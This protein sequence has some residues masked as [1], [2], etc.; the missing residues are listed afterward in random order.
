M[1]FLSYYRVETLRIFCSKT[2]WLVIALSL[3]AP[4]LGLTVFSS[5]FAE[6]RAVTLIAQP[7][8]TAA[9]I[10]AVLWALLTLFELDRVHKAGSAVLTDAI[11][12]PLALSAAKL[13][14]LL[15]A[16]L[17][18]GVLAM[19]AYLPYT[20]IQMGNIFDL[21]DYLTIYT[22]FLTAT[23]LIGILFAAIFYQV[24]RR[25][26]LSFILFVVC[27]FV[28]LSEYFSGDYILRWL[29]PMLPT[30][31]DDFSNAWPIRLAVYNRL[32]WLLLLSGLYLFSALCIRRY[33]KG[34][35]GSFVR[36]MRK[37]AIPVL[38]VILVFGGMAAYA[39]QPYENDAPMDVWNHDCEYNEKAFL[40]STHVDFTP[41]IHNISQKG[42]ATYKVLNENKEAY[43][44]RAFI[45]CGYKVK[46][47]T[48]N[49]EPAAFVDLNDDLLWG[50]HIEFVI[51][52]VRDVEIVLE[53]GGIPQLKQ[54]AAASTLLIGAEEAERR[55]ISFSAEGFAP[56]LEMDPPP[57]KG[58]QFTADV[59]LP[60]YMTPLVARGTAKLTAE[61]ADGTK[62]WRLTSTR[63]RLTFYAG[64]YVCQ[65]VP[66][67]DQYVG[68]YYSRKHEDVM[69]RSNIQ[70]VLQETML[71][72]LNSIGTPEWFL[73]QEA[74]KLVQ[75]TSYDSG[76]GAV[77]G[78]STMYEDS[79]SETT[80]SD[81][82]RGAGP[83]EVM[84]HEI[85]HQWWGLGRMFSDMSGMEEE[86]AW[87]S[88]G[89]TVYSTYRLMQEK[90]GDAYA[91]E[92]Y[93]DVWQAEV[94]AM[95]RDF[96]NRH[97]EYLDILPEQYS[98]QIRSG[99]W[100][101]R[102]YCE[103]PL[104]ILKA[105]S[106]VGG[107]AAMDEILQSLFASEDNEFPPF[108]SFQ[109]FLDACGLTKEDIAL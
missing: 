89:M 20:A 86:Y 77:N 11:V 16:G 4:L 64:D 73:G 100:G 50:K 31:S 37:A 85:L 102:Q 84:A 61:Q 96:Y 48:I 40:V 55:Y 3:I 52:P 92:H 49:G 21:R 44:Q 56:Y 7:V 39:V 9:M 101:T 83:A 80:L 95:N 8:Q 17:A 1:S 38:A 34:L 91:K 76:G 42:T 60:G 99:I 28:S 57:D 18:T 59:T 88:E 103:M 30:L 10:G 108:L 87:S 22:V 66:L 93:V 45:R 47:L 36:N 58:H 15:T 75:T 25:I 6:T 19:L 12:S 109:D 67:K 26:D 97:P 106:L 71:Y 107:G 90:Y 33:G 14:A 23:L 94:D 98:A 5:G 105:E 79:F 69:A 43:T 104:R 70:D 32:F 27:V 41:N 81:P 24:T 68:F 78:M 63:N 35:I 54:A 2:T 74:L 13:L 29:H 62:L 65:E 72:G 53:Y 51:P 82:L 46:S